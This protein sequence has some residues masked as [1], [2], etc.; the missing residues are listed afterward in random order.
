MP[1][2]NNR[3]A[4]FVLVI[5]ASSSACGAQQKA[6][7]PQHAEYWG[8]TGPW[9]AASDS[10]VRRHGR[11]LDVV[12]TGW[13]GLDSATARPLLPSPY[14]DTLL[15]RSRT[16]RRMAIVTS[17]H[18]DRF[19]PRTIRS[20]AANAQ[21]LAATA[22]VIA[23]H[24][25]SMTYSGL[26][27]DFESLEPTDLA[28]QV[29]VIRAIAEAARA[30]GVSQIAVAIPAM[31]TSGY[32]IRPLLDAA[33]YV[34]VMLYDQH[35]TGSDPGPISDPAWVK[36]ALASRIAE[37][38]AGRI[39]AGLPTYAY[40]WRRG[41]PTEILGYREAAAIARKEGVPLKR[42]KA[43]ATLRAKRGTAWDMWV[44]DAT[45]MQRLIRDARTAGVYRFALWRLGQ[46]DPAIWRVLAR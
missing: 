5:L 15:S 25:A 28:A 41:Q 6:A 19:H 29:T 45:L 7:A 31:D 11:A 23:E 18:G 16:P 32:P 40:R 10:S 9:E 43:T 46:E 26:V 24:A 35:W 3:F 8:F 34:I 14:P 42:D 36:G 13:I 17:W 44:T 27:M 33:D 12:V 37:G 1:Q 30:R 21:L 38:G 2:I 22:R 4:S 39:V 20:L